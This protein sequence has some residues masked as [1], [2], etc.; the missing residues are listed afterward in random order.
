MLGARALMF[1]SRWFESQP[2]VLLES[3]AA[4]LRAICE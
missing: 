2:L 4:G 3:L 1:P